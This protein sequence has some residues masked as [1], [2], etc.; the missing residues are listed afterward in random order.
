MIESLWYIL[1]KNS[2]SL[3]ISIVKN[4]RKLIVTQKELTIKHNPIYE[5]IPKSSIAKIRE[6]IS[7]KIK[8]NFILVKRIASQLQFEILN[9][10]LWIVQ[11]PYNKSNYEQERVFKSKESAV[12]SNDN[13]PQLS[14]NEEHKSPSLRNDDEEIKINSD[15][16]NDEEELFKI[17][18]LVKQK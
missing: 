18:K 17:L 10:K 11:N 3:V 1:L 9:D 12:L 13:L 5:Y 16:I 7:L 4:K 15:F 2:D 6:F 8:N 14:F